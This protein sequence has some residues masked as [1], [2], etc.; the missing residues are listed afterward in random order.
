M[1]CVVACVAGCAVGCVAVCVLGCVAGKFSEI[2]RRN[3]TN[4]RR[5]HDLCFLCKKIE[6]NKLYLVRGIWLPPGPRLGGA[7]YLR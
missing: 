3:V 2:G 6:I 7:F 4:T 1:G 5:K